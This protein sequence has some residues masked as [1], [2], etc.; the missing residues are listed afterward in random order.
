MDTYFYSEKENLNIFS[1]RGASGIDGN[2]ST[3]A[4]IHLNSQAETTALV[5]DLAFLYDLN[6]LNLL[7]DPK[8][9]L[10]VV[11][12]NNDGGGIFSTLPIKDYEKHESYFG[13]PHGLNFSE[14]CSGF[15]IRYESPKTPEEFSS[16][17]IKSIKENHTTVIE[18]KTSRENLL[19]DHLRIQKKV[20]DE[21]VH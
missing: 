5:G 14:F 2:L 1:N 6:S 21:F 11:A 18:V 8:K 13:T 9:P 3:L 7:K 4:G 17:Y 10:V 19:S 15:G 12:I 20:E 16:T